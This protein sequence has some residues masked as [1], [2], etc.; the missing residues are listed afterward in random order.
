[1]IILISFSFYLEIERYQEEVEYYKQQV[2]QKELSEIELINEICRLN[3]SISSYN[4]DLDHLFEEFSQINAQIEGY[5]EEIE[6]SIPLI[7]SIYN[8]AINPELVF[9]VIKQESGFNPDAV[10]HNTNGTIDR[11]LMQIN[12]GTAPWLWSQVFPNEPYDY[13]KLYDPETNL[14]LGI[15]YL[16]YLLEKFQNEHKALTAYNRGEGGLNSYMSRYGTAESR[17]SRSVLGE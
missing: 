10:N 4:Q 8:E 7:F 11:G 5:E 6:L 2:L 16:N 17:Y 9:G 1:M 14:K 13:K 15:W 12:S 3:L